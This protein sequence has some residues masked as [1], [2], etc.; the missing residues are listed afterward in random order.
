MEKQILEKMGIVP[1]NKDAF[2]IL[3]AALKTLIEYSDV[4]NLYPLKNESISVLN[5]LKKLNSE[6]I[7]YIDSKLSE[8]NLSIEECQIKVQKLIPQ[9][10][11]KK[12]AAYYTIES[13]SKFMASMVEKYLKKLDKDRIVIV[14]PFM[15]SGMAITQTLELIKSE[16]V[17]KVWG[18]EPLPLPAL[19]AYA[20]I[21]TALNGKGDLIEIVVGDAFEIVLRDF[22]PLNTK[23]KL[24]KADVILTNPPFTRWKYLEKDY[25]EFLLKVISDWGYEKYITRKEISLQT[26]CLY[27]S[28]YVLNQNGLIISVLP[29]STF[30]TIYGKGYK[31]LLKSNYNTFGILESSSRSSFS[32][33]SG[34][35]EVILAAIKGSKASFT[36]FSE[37]NDNSQEITDFLMENNGSFYNKYSHD[38]FD[39]NNLPRFLDINWLSLFGKRDLRNFLV[40]IFSEGFEKGTLEYWEDALGSKSIIRGV[41]M[42]GPEFFFIPNKYW[43]L[44]HET[45][46]NLII[47]K[48]EDKKVLKL[49]KKFFIK[50]FRKPSLYDRI[51]ESPLESYMLSLPPIE[52]NDLNKDLRSYIE[53]G[54]NS[55][56]A[57]PAIKSYG[58]FWYSHVYKQMSTKKPFGHIIIPDKVDLGFKRRGVFANYSSEDAAA[59]KN[60][61]IVKDKDEKV[62][63]ILAAWFNSTLFFCIL[64]LLGRKISNTWTRLLRNDYLEIPLINVENLDENKIK[65]LCE[66]FDEISDQKLDPFWDQLG[67]S[68]RYELDLAVLK[69]L[70]IKNPENKVKKMYKILKET[71]N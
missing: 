40:D 22:S 12:F 26:L 42:Y 10:E 66:I 67:E 6:E 13:G 71:N 68:F 38:L 16:K 60:F 54:V 41:E 45:S 56:S 59:S 35:K 55:E 46:N 23:S 57:L 14:D 28:D 19:V 53:W 61:Y 37:L 36:A 1:V 25:R 18:I 29:V 20:A 48:L 34:F 44:D 5:I 52:Y 7:E 11:R 4:N 17:K 15:G 3:S 32:E 69:G 33:D 43:K 27:L 50:T 65:D 70:G 49:E 51:I 39:I 58:K 9:G 63:K 2:D 31:W 64:A 30:Y 24:S 47:S 21:L 8:N 62:A